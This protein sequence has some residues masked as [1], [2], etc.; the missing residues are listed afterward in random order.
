MVITVVL[1]QAQ[2]HRAENREQKDNNH[3][4]DASFHSL[5]S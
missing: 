3:G 5:L 4:L 2:L 1:G